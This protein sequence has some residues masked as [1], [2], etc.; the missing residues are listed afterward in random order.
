MG[1]LSRNFNTKEFRCKCGC[2][3]VRVDPRLVK[4]LQCMRDNYG[5]PIKI[6]SGFRCE[7][8]NEAVGGA[9]DSAHLVG[10]AAD[11][12]VETSKQRFRLVREAVNAGFTRIGIG[13]TLIHVDVSVSHPQNVMWVYDY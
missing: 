6:T 12:S 13:S 4:G 2:G 7:A 11:L 5:G 10:A 1:D 8:H 3:K 9:S